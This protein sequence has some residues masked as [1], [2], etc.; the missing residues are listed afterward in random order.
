M[1]HATFGEGTVLSATPMGGDQM[2]EVDFPVGKKKIMANFA[3]I[4]KI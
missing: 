4:E 2:L 1:K 3:P